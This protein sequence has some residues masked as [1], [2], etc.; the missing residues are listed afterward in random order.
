MLFKHGVT[1]LGASSLT[2]AVVEYEFTRCLSQLQAQTSLPQVLFVDYIFF[3]NICAHGLSCLYFLYIK[4]KIILLFTAFSKKNTP[5]FER[6]FS[7]G[8]VDGV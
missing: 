2:H 6:I 7:F 8:A 1:S 5:E 4:S 3:N